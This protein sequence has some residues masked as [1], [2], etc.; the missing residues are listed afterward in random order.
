MTSDSEFGRYWR[1]LLPGNY[2]VR[3]IKDSSISEEKTVQISNNEHERLDFKVELKEP[4]LKS[5]TPAE[6]D[7]ST[8]S[9]ITSFL[10]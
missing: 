2:L 4:E 3:A 9:I 8:G 5:I 7:L 1:I 6:S 10:F